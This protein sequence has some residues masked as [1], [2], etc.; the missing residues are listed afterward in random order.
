M[1]CLTIDLLLGDSRRT[2]A[3]GIDVASFKE[4]EKE[5]TVLCFVDWDSGLVSVTAKD[6]V[7]FSS[8]AYYPSFDK[9]DAM[10]APGGDLSNR[11]WIRRVF[12]HPAPSFHAADC[13]GSRSAAIGQGPEFCLV[14]QAYR[15]MESSATQSNFHARSMVGTRR[16]PRVA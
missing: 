2:P 12:L 3:A 11:K 15:V 13:G 16:A 4:P 1:A 9:N 10:P 7:P 14:R 5:L 6:P 8:V